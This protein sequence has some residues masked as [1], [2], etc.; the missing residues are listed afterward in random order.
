MASPEPA[1]APA[2]EAL[3][4]VGIAPAGV[5]S[6]APPADPERSAEEFVERTRKE[7]SDAVDALTKERAELRARLAKVEAGLTRYKATLEALKVQVPGAVQVIGPEGV[8]T[9]VPSDKTPGEFV[10]PPEPSAPDLQPIPPIPGPESSP[11]P[12]PK[13][14]KV[15]QPPSPTDPGPT[16]PRSAD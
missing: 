15:P 10:A 3:S 14:E 12:M 1:L 13:E 9:V 11:P 7:A 4:G 16:P 8:R 5:A 6:P 2:T